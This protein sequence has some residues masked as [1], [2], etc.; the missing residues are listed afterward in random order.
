MTPCKKQ[1][2]IFLIP[3][4]TLDGLSNDTTHNS[5][6]WLYR[7]AKIDWT[8]KAIWA[9]EYIVP[10][11]TKGDRNYYVDI[12]YDLIKLKITHVDNGKRGTFVIVGA[13]ILVNFHPQTAIDFVN[14]Q[15]TL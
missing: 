3:Y 15:F 4:S 9:F 8:K 1:K 2:K 5:L 14:S 11:P 12:K 6:R 7:S 13:I 10:S